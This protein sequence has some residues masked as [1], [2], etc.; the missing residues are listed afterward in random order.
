M[1]DF[2]VAGIQD[3]IGKGTQGPGAPSLEVAL[4]CGG[5][6]IGLGLEHSG[7]FAAHGFIDEEADALAEALVALLGEEL[8]DG[9]QEI[10][11]VWWVMYSWVVDVFR[12][13]PTR[14]PHDPPSTSFWHGAT[15]RR[16]HIY[17]KEFTPPLLGK[18]T[19]SIATYH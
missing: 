15:G 1:A 3:E 19:W 8:Q 2:F 12:E 18:Q 17:R 13:T 5:A 16:E 6:L 11:A 9:V 14:E 7:A 4:A 10:R